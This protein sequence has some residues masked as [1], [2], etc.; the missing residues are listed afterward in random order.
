M[1]NENIRHGDLDEVVKSLVSIDEYEPKTGKKEDI[2]VIGFYV[3][4]EKVGKDLENFLQKSHFNF[5]DVEVT[6]NPNEDN[7]YCLLYTSPSPRDG[8]L[9]RMPSSA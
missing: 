9:S 2:S 7:M 3:T 1:I 4:E 6:P 8:L 5:R